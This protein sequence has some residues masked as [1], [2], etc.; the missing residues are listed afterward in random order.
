MD[1][2]MYEDWD[3]SHPFNLPEEIDLGQHLTNQE[4]KTEEPS[5][6]DDDEPPL[7][8]G[9]VLSAN[10]H[11]PGPSLDPMNVSALKVRR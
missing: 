1:D 9:D 3:G 10:G 4:T 7:S 2:S 8:I 11:S 6:L 5:S